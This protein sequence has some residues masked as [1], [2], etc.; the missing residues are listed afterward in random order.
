M[1][2]ITAVRNAP[3][4]PSQRRIIQTTATITTPKSATWMRALQS[5]TPNR[6]YMSGFR[7]NLSGPCIIGWCW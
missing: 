2:Y 3:V 1:V 4:R 7:M 6:K 5:L